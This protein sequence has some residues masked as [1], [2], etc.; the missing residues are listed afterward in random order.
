MYDGS[1]LISNVLMSDDGSCLQLAAAASSNPSLEMKTST[2]KTAG[3]NEGRNE[4]KKMGY[5]VH[6][7]SAVTIWMS[8][9]LITSVLR[10]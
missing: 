4:R 7:I 9:A 2:L 8:S 6:S 1:R 10:T 3:S 5:R